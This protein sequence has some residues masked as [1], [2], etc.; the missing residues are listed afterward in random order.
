LQCVEEVFDFGT[1]WHQ[2][3]FRSIERQLGAKGSRYV[4]S[5]GQYYLDWAVAFSR[6]SA[7]GVKDSTQIQTHMCFTEFNDLMEAIAANGC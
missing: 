3:S 4:Q 2:I 6:L 5:H 7:N 1:G